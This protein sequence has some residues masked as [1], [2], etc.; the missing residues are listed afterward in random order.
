MGKT[1]FFEGPNWPKI[2]GYCAYRERC[3]SEVREKLYSFGLRRNEVE[4]LISRLIEEDVL[5]EQR[6][7]DL[8]AGGHFRQKRWGRQKIVYALRQKKVS[9]PVIKKALKEIDGPDYTTS[10]QKLARVKWQALKGEQYLTRQA[11]TMAYL[12]QKGY[13]RPAVLAVV[14]QLQANG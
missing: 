7:A 5:N 3:H 9:E 12:L 4:T 10:L 6:F 2:R 14:K 13:E 1:P 11:K 8:F